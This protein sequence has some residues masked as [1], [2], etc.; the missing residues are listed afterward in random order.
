[1]LA[2]QPWQRAGL[3]KADAREI[4]GLVRGPGEDHRAE[5][6]R[7]QEHDLAVGQ[8]RREQLPDIGL[9]EGRGGAQDQLDVAHGRGNVRCHQRQLH[10]VPAVAVLDDDAGA[11]RAM[12][13]DQIRI[14]PPQPDVMTLQ[15]KIAGSREGAI[16]AAEYRDLQSGPP[17]EV[18]GVSSWRSMKCCTL[19]SAVRGRSSTNTISR[20]TLKRAS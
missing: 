3:G 15:G 6:G 13:R 16:A 8:M 7:R 17:C 11:C 1:M 19:P 4:A 20:G 12:L 9:G 14:T 2:G 18:V 10:I 5:G